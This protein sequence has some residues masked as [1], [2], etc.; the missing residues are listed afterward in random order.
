L[1]RRLAERGVHR[2]G[3]GVTHVREYV[4]VDVEG[5]AYVGMAQKLLDVLGVDTLPQEKRG[6]RVAEIVEAYLG[7][8]GT[9]EQGFEGAVEVP[10]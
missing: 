10:A 2:A 7:K 3:G 8:S 6:A 5:K 1:Q 9:L 4:R